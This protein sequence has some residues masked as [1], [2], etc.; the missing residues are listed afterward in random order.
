MT[1]RKTKQDIPTV[2]RPS[3]EAATPQSDQTALLQ[4][5]K[6]MYLDMKEDMKAMQRDMAALRKEIKQ[7]IRQEIR[8]ELKDLK[9]GLGKATKDI[10]KIEEN[11]ERM[12]EKTTKI[13]KRVMDIEQNFERDLDERALQDLK[14]RENCIKIRGLKEKENEDLYEYLTP[15]LANYAGADNEQFHW[16][17]SKMFRINSKIAKQKK[18]PRDIIIY[19]TRKKTRDEFIQLS[20]EEKLEIEGEELI[21]FKDIPSRILK[22]RMDYKPLTTILNKCNINYRWERL[23]GI[24]F[25]FKNELFR[26]NSVMKMKDFI[27]KH[28]DILQKGL[29][30]QEKEENKEE[31]EEEK[32]EEEERQEDRNQ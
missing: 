25:R 5:L 14:Q 16:E 22:K 28:R 31:K 13:N 27:K 24:S 4:E 1:S 10:K 15:H 18:L 20:Y 6:S 21:I 3:L 17:I 8:S 11:M 23:E 30:E 12:E 29:N 26:I 9:E 19:F 32:A 2:R 7:E